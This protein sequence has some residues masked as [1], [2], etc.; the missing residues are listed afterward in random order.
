M[1]SEAVNTCIVL[2]GR[3]AREPGGVVEI[4]ALEESIRISAATMA[5]QLQEYGWQDGDVG[6]AI[7]AQ[8]VVALAN[9]SR[10]NG[11]ETDAEALQRIGELVRSLAPSF[12]LQV[13][14]SL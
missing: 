10:V 14:K 4:D 7:F 9:A 3:K 6:M 5:P 13:R 11:V 8:G 2:V 1:T 12:K